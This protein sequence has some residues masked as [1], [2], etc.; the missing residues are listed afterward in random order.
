M[1]CE[2]LARQSSQQQQQ[3]QIQMII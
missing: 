2:A 3:L 1:C